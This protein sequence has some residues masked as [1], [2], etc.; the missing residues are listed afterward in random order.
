MVAERLVVDALGTVL[1]VAIKQR[2]QLALQWMKIHQSV[3]WQSYALKKSEQK[4]R[5][6]I[7]IILPY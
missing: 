5:R 1:V 4:T 2:F 3:S 7:E 6:R